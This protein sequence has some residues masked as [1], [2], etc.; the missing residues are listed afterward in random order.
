MIHVE[1]CVAHFNSNGKLQVVKGRF[2]KTAKL[3]LLAED[4]TCHPIR[5]AL[6]WSSRFDHGDWRLANTPEAALVALFQREE[7]ALERAIEKVEASKAR[8]R[9]IAMKQAEYALGDGE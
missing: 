3:Y 7:R 9:L 1:K 2:R 6:S 5:G 4:D 8:I